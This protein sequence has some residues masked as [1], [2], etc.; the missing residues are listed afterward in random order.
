MAEIRAYGLE[1]IKVGDI[2]AG[3]AMGTSLSIL[4][5][6]YENTAELIQDDPDITE[7]KSEE[8]IEPEE[9]FEVE[10]T[11]RINWSIMNYDPDEIVKVLGGTS[12]GTEPNK[13][14]SS[15]I[16]KEPIELS[17]EFK[18]KTGHIVQIARAKITAKLN[19]TIRKNGVALIEIQ[20]RIM[21]PTDGTSSPIVVTNPAAST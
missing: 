18:T 13:T 16:T 4:G 6:T 19:W 10:G 7:I 2:G 21:T 20:G 11:K 3:G 9:I 14:W 12:T 17:I 5:V 8:N 1:Y 15:P